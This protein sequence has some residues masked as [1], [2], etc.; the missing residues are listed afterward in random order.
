MGAPTRDELMALARRADQTVSVALAGVL[1]SRWQKH[2]LE[3]LPL[4]GLDTGAT[5]QLIASHFPGFVTLLPAGALRVPHDFGEALEL[6]DLL[7]LLLSHRSHADHDNDWLAHAI[8]TACVGAD[9]L[10]QDMNLPSRAVL[11]QLLHGFFTVL[12]ERNRKDMKWKK[13]FYLCLCESAEIRVCKAPSC[14]ACD[15]YLHCFG[16]EV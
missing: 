9:H 12:A 16:P 15:D 4:Y 1:C 14:G 2:G 3:C 6:E 5:R 11:S 10:W 8:T 13:F 7:Y